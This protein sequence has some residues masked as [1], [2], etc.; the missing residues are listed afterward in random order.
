M[1]PL[2]LSS[3]SL[4]LS[5]SLSLTLL[6]FLFLSLLFDFFLSLSLSLS[7]PPT[8]SSAFLPATDS[9]FPSS[10]HLSLGILGNESELRPHSQRSASCAKETR[11]CCLAGATPQTGWF[12]CGFP[13]EYR[14]GTLKRSSP[15][16]RVVG[17]LACRGNRQVLRKSREAQTLRDPGCQI[18]RGLWIK[19]NGIP[20]WGRCTTHFSLF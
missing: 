18:V 10:C 16:R 12:S 1:P 13:F 4:T 8:G 3:S 19:A 11:G 5:L 15:D 17:S 6:F 20:F 9:C 2:F 7:L 14:T